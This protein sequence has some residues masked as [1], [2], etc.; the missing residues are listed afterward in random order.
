MEYIIIV[1]LLLIRSVLKDAHRYNRK[2]KIDSVFWYLQ[3]FVFPILLSVDGVLKHFN[4]IDITLYAISIGFL[5]E[6]ISFIVEKTKNVKDKKAIKKLT[7]GQSFKNV[8]GA[9]HKKHPKI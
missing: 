9:T 4:I 6:L 2:H 1:T 8:T 5:F 7:I 3:P